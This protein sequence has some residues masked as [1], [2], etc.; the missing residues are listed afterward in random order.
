MLK[1]VEFLVGLFGKPPNSEILLG[2]ED[3]GVVKGSDSLGKLS[4]VCSLWKQ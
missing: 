1:K 3:G 4:N 2:I